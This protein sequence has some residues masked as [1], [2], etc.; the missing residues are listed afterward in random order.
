M[1]VSAHQDAAYEF[2][3][4]WLFRDG[5]VPA[6]ILSIGCL[7]MPLGTS[8]MGLLTDQ[9]ADDV[10]LM[11]LLLLL[12]PFAALNF[13]FHSGHVVPGAMDNL[14]GIC[15]LMGLSPLLRDRLEHTEVLLLATSSEECG[16]RGAKAFAQA[17]LSEFAGNCLLP[18]RGIFVD[19]I[20]DEKHLTV[21]TREL[22]TGAKHDPRLVAMAERVAAALGFPCER[23]VIP[24]GASDAS[25][26]S[27]SGI[28]SLSILCQD[29][30]R[31]VHNYHTRDDTIELVKPSSM[32]TTLRLV[33]SMLEIIDHS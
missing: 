15:V 2:N 5:G 12:W 29:T 32:S 10:S 27:T 13:M 33:Y 21:V 3:L 26:F 20:Y 11:A 19:G 30:H 16:L 7:L 22:T 4:W 17:H 28:P 1:V 14:A 9:G 8:L 31:L 6:M 24:F 18:T 25:A 23:A